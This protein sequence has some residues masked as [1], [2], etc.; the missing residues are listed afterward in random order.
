MDAEFLQASVEAYVIIL[1]KLSVKEA[2][3]RNQDLLIK[4]NQ[5]F[6]GVKTYHN[7]FTVSVTTSF[8]RFS[9]LQNDS[10]REGVCKKIQ[11]S[12]MQ[13]LF[14]T[15][16]AE[17]A[18]FEHYS[19]CP[20]PYCP[21][22]SHYCPCHPLATTYWSCIRLCQ[23]SGA[24][25]THVQAHTYTGPAGCGFFHA[26]GHGRPLKFRISGFYFSMLDS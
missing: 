1:P 20:P 5:V 24:T 14:D 9:S 11:R 23:L 22:H 10:L 17:I 18:T 25:H 26:W 2:K 7:G 16:L 6:L 8:M 12:G 15:R 13:K 4:F 3:E 21:A 19:P